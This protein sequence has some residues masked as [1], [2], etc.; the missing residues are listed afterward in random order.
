[1]KGMIDHYYL[2]KRGWVS[3]EGVCDDKGKLAVNQEYTPY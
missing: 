1:M 2:D 3:A